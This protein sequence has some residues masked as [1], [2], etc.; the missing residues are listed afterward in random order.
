MFLAVMDRMAERKA[1]AQETGD[2][3]T[4]ECL[5]AMYDGIKPE[6]YLVE[7]IREIK[8]AH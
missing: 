1:A 5:A 4:A 6:D 8:P 3:E 7:P 2:I